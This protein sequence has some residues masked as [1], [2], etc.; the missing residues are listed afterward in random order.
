MDVPVAMYDQ[1]EDTSADD[2]Q[3]TEFEAV[4]LIGPSRALFSRPFN[5]LPM[6]SRVILMYALLVN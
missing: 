4:S 1:S 5:F 6:P 3:G 2:L